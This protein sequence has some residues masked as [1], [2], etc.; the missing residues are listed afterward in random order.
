V[1][2]APESLVRAHR[3]VASF[4]ILGDMPG[5]ATA[6][7]AATESVRVDKHSLVH[8][9]VRVHQGDEGGQ[10]EARG[11]GDGQVC[12]A[13]CSM[14]EHLVLAP[15]DPRN[16]AKLAE[17]AADRVVREDGGDASEADG[18]DGVA[19]CP[20]VD[21]GAPARGPGDA[22]D[23]AGEM[24]TVLLSSEESHEEQLGLW[25][26]PDISDLFD[27]DLKVFDQEIVALLYINRVLDDAQVDE[28]C[29][30]R[31]GG[32]VVERRV[33]HRGAWR[34][35]GRAAAAPQGRGVGIRHMAARFPNVVFALREKGSGGG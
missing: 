32:D 31:E 34:T 20:A 17:V 8:T 1:K 5:S 24:P 3:P 9:S 15:K 10:R 22:G 29:V 28:Y 12:N 27:L 18:G 13:I 35:A 2:R 30:C 7:A 25:L 21:E 6:R 19:W 33:L 23:E 4:A 14:G 11:D 16:P 26:R